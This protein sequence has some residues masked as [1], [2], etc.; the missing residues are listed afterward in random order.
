MSTT[1]D[2]SHMVLRLGLA[3]FGEGQEAGQGGVV[4][5]GPEGVLGGLAG[6]GGQIAGGQIAGGQIT[7]GQIDRRRH[8]P[9]Q[10]QVKSQRMAH[11][12]ATVRLFHGPPKRIMR[13]APGCASWRAAKF[14][15]HP[16]V[17]RGLRFVEE[18]L[19]Q[20]I[21]EDAKRMGSFTK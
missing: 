1:K 9:E 4:I 20:A 7:G 14:A 2:K 15:A 6:G 17:V 11:D 3:G 12:L 16:M 10:T 19:K 5:L 18:V 21:I 8:Q 13:R